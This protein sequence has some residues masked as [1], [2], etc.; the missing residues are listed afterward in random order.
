MGWP[1]CL[2]G[3]SEEAGTGRTDGSCRSSSRSGSASKSSSPKSAAAFV[4]PS[5]TS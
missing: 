1:C 2:L 4:T 3:G 5:C